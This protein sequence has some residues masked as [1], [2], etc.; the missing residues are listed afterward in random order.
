MENST[1]V[2]AL[3]EKYFSGTCTPDETI[4]AQ[5]YMRDPR[6]YDT[7]DRFMDSKWKEMPDQGN[8]HPGTVPGTDRYRKIRNRIRPKRKPVVF[9]RVAAALLIMMV[10]GSLYLYRS[11]LLNTFFP[12]KMIS[13]STKP[14]EQLTVTLPDGSEVWLNTASTIQYPDAF[15]G[16][17]RDIN[18]TGEA[19]LR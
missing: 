5:Q 4:K 10:A 2:E 12:V 17:T 8:F 6:F 16:E 7:L 18:L 11:A 3:F 19:F 9:L 13:L 15:R 14:G 1:D